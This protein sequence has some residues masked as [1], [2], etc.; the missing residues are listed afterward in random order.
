MFLLHVVRGS[1]VSPS[2]C[3]SEFAFSPFISRPPACRCFSDV[4]VR[5]SVVLASSVVRF[6]QSFCL[7]VPLLPLSCLSGRPLLWLYG[8]DAFCVFQSV[9]RQGKSDFYGIGFDPLAN[10]PEFKG[11]F[12]FSVSSM[13]ASVLSAGALSG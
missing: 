11:W 1:S 3:L 4:C 5:I 7:R 12:R 10:A 9:H 2:L 13:Y 6:L 8:A